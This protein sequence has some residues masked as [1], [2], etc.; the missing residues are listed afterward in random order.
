[1]LFH[2]SDNP[3]IV[4]FEPRL[5]TSTSE[6]L[7]WAVDAA[8]LRNY[9]VPRECPRVTY[10]A[11]PRTTVT[12]RE[13]FLSSSDAVAAIESIWLERVRQCRLFCYHL[14]AD[15]FERVDE[16]A[17][18]FVSRSPVVPVH[19]EAFDNVISELPRRRVEVR[20]EAN[21]WP[22]RDAVIG[23]TLLFSMIRMRNALPREQR[24]AI[25]SNT[26]G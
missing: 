3:T 23:S 9:L 18:Y 14:P 25:T 2:V 11:G 17:G 1:M 12:D 8:R 7:V 19:V 6:R 22:L 26:G 24:G 10:Y 5:S 20:I 15:T 13:L 4:R 21:L 16:C